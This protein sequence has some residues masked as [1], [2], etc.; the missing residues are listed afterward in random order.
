[1]RRTR[2]PGRDRSEPDDDGKTKTRRQ[3]G[4]EE[5]EEE[6]EEEDDDDGNEMEEDV[7]ELAANAPRCRENC[8]VIALRK[9][10]LPSLPKATAVLEHFY[11]SQ[12]H[13]TLEECISTLES[14]STNPG[15][16]SEFDDG[17]RVAVEHLRGRC[18]AFARLYGNT[19]F[20]EL[21]QGAVTALDDYKGRE[22]VQA[23]KLVED[24]LRRY[25]FIITPRMWSKYEI[26][27]IMCIL[28]D[29]S[30]VYQA[31][32]QKTGL[33]STETYQNR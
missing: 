27:L 2:H 3:N 17:Y 30:L 18:T 23:R 1:M 21:C 9:L 22:S 26:C 15:D 19:A 32:N 20:N 12:S 16:H 24:H 13:W 4:E 14:L 33:P 25:A 8:D 5:E 28:L 29:S 11:W 7:A 10:G 31:I 6:D